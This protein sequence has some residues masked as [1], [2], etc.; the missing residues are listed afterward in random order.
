MPLA[1]CGHIDGNLGDY[2]LSILYIYSSR[3]RRLVLYFHGNR[4][5]CRKYYLSTYN[6]HYHAECR[7]SRLNHYI[8]SS[9]L[10]R[11]YRS[12]QWNP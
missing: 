1:P 6:Y 11:D 9:L 3:N 2:K 12:V 5:G 4:D 8:D 7:S 10:Q